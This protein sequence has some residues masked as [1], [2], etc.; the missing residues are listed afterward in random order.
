M[1]KSTTCRLRDIMSTNDTKEI[2]INY[3]FYRVLSDNITN[4][5]ETT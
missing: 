1:F 4:K 5:Y 3:H 2:D